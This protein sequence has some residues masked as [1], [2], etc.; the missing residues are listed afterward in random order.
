MAGEHVLRAVEPLAGRLLEE[1]GAA[2]VH[3][4]LFA[5][6]LIEPALRQLLVEAGRGALL[7]LARR[8]GGLL[9]RGSLRGR[10]RRQA[11]GVALGHR[12]G[13]RRR[14]RGRLTGEEQR[15]EGCSNG[16]GCY[17][18]PPLPL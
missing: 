16:H 3:R 2:R 9:A 13:R 4:A 18:A 17:P 5:A 14:R 11:G 10:A 1:R 12:L 6:V 8:R 15:D 7:A